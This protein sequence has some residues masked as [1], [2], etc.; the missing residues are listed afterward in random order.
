M[1]NVRPNLQNVCLVLDLT[2]HFLLGQI[3]SFLNPRTK[4]QEIN[5]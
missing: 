5:N 4:N 2:N 3:Q 1:C